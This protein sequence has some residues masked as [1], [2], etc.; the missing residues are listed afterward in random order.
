VRA[1]VDAV[2][3]AHP[4]WS[5][6]AVWEELE[7]Q[8]QEPLPS[9][10]TVSRW[11]EARRPSGPPRSGDRP[12]RRFE[13]A[14]PLDLVQMDTT[15]GR[16]LAGNRMAYI[17]T[18]LDDYSR[19]VLAAQAVA[20]DSTA[21]NLGVL[22]AAVAA[23]GPMR[24]LYTDNGSVFRTTRYAGSR[25]YVYAPEVLAGEAPTQLARAVGELGAVLLTHTIGNARAKGKLER[26][27]R[28][29]QERLLAD[30]QYPDLGLLDQ[31]LQAWVHRYNAH[32]YH[33]TIGCAPNARLVGHTPRPLP[34]GAL[35]LPDICALRETRKVAKDHTVSLE[36]LHYPLP[37][38]PNRVDFTVELRIRP[39]Q[40]VR[41]WHHQQLV[42]ELPH[43]GPPPTD[44]LSVD[45]ILEQ[46]LP[47]AEPKALGTQPPRT[48]KTTLREGGR[49]LLP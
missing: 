45:Q 40:T 15:S 25:F 10:R 47:R 21:N 43:E 4:R 8:G 1:A 2:A 5:A 35:P 24:V 42:C 23:Y 14:R 12:A 49:T 22:E 46:V 44:G 19:A 39:G 48:R 32:H 7:A 36:G 34:T 27:H 13:A 37:R 29:L 33:R 11:L 20:Q 17:I 31:A 3:D 28:F 9:R 16:W 26:W 18:L 30:G 41:I 6:S 38:E